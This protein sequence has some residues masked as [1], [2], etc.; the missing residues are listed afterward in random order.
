[1]LIMSQFKWNGENPPK[2][3][4]HK[5]QEGT[6]YPDCHSHMH[7]WSTGHRDCSQQPHQE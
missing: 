4:R 7:W 3:S 5:A 6:G 2:T 1:M